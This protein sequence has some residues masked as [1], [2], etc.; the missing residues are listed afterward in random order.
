M[1]K[2]E[3]IGLL[4]RC[5]GELTDSEIITLMKRVMYLPLCYYLA[6]QAIVA[7]GRWRDKQYPV[8]YVKKAA[9]AKAI[10]MG[11]AD[12]PHE[13]STLITPIL[14]KNRQRGKASSK[15]RVPIAWDEFYDYIMAKHELGVPRKSGGVWKAPG[16]LLDWKT[17]SRAA[18]AGGG[19]REFRDQENHPITAYEHLVQRIPADLRRTVTVPV[20]D[21]KGARWLRRLWKKNN[22]DMEMPAG[23]LMQEETIEVPDW[24][25]IAERAGLDKG[26]EYVLQLRVDGYGR[27]RAMAMQRT[28]KGKR[29]VQA[30]WRRLSRKWGRVVS[31]INP[32]ASAN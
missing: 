21:P 3:A 23:Y 6:V 5:T 16:D 2:S 27:D 28:A 25:R 14:I 26:E 4:E 10:H 15:V 7:E 32:G 18:G 9:M 22:P 20:Y 30:A 8:A 1:D 12:D 24:T 13:R 29:S 17:A 19:A 31:V 11:L